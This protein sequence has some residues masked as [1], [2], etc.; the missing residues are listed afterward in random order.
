MS[1]LSDIEQLRRQM[2]DRYRAL[3][4]LNQQILQL[5]SVIY[6]PVSRAT[7]LE[8]LNRA[9]IH[10]AKR[11]PFVVATLKSSLDTLIAGGFLIQEKS[12]GPQCQ[13]LLSEVATRDAIKAGT[14]GTWVEAVEAC[15]PIRQSWKN[16]PRS[17]SSEAQFVREI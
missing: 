11:K 13:P 4:E 14:F 6:G 10:D 2:V 1:N 16:G 15:I 7:F 8:C 12:Q 9:G 5:F 3:P 17:F